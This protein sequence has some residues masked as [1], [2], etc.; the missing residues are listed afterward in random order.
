MRTP[1]DE[2][3]HIDAL[4]ATLDRRARPEEVA[5]LILQRP[6]GLDRAALRGLQVLAGTARF[7]GWY[8]SMSGDFERPE[9]PERL[10]GVA[11]ALLDADFEPHLRGVEAAAMVAWAV[12]GCAPATEYSSR[13]DRRG[14]AAAG[15]EL[16]R[17]RYDKTFRL[18]MALEGKAARMRAAEERRRWSMIA[19]SGLA[20]EIFRAQLPDVATARFVA[21]F[22]AR[23]HRRSIF[24]AGS[25]ERPFDEVC[26]SLL[27]AIPGAGPGSGWGAAAL[28]WPA[29][30]VL[31]RLTDA[32]RGQLLGRWSQLMTALALRLG[33]EWER[34][35]FDPAMVVRRGD[36]SSTWNALAGAFNKARSGWIATLYALGLGAALEERLPGKCM[37]LMAADVVWWHRLSGGDMEPDTTVWCRLPKPWDVVSGE[38]ECGRGLVAQVCRDSGVDPVGSGWA[39]PRPKGAPAPT[40]ATPELVHGVRVFDPLLAGALRRAG[41]FSGK[42]LKQA[43][44]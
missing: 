38:A 40:T 42:G 2:H 17:R 15:I 25:Q 3:I 24:T 30:E 12:V 39:A 1:D 44:R 14:R 8:S 20:S 33:E 4:H 31:A 16:S 21:Y 19:K 18:A 32:Q 10:M 9:L 28:C 7:W 29:P 13:L 41:V 6:D 34:G 36:D 43:A 27:A 11:S 37:R 23:A 5:S 26:E 22:A 35:D